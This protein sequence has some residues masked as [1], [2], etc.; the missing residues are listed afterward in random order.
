MRRGTRKRQAE[1]EVR[2]RMKMRRVK[3]AGG[4]RAIIKGKVRS[5]MHV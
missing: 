5:G 2:W 4:M 3:R 1:M